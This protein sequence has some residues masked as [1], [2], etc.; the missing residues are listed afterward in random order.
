MIKPSPQKHIKVINF[1][2]NTI[3]L[4]KKFGSAYRSK[5]R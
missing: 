1:D 2:L 5:Y 3:S 4:E